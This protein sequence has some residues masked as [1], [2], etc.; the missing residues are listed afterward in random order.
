VIGIFDS[1]LGGLTVLRRVRAEL[2][3][4]PL[5]YFADQAHVPYG[6]RSEADL[7]GLLRRN[8][9][10]LEAQGADFIVMGCNTSCA[11]GRRYGW[12]P[13]G[14]PILDLIDAAA[15]AV[16][17]AG[18]RRVGVIATSATANSGEYGAA[19]R[20]RVPGAEV[21]E[22]GAPELVPLVEAGK[23]TGPAA[24]DAVHR[25]CAP[26]A[27]PLDM[28]VLA[29]THF[30]LLDEHFESAFGPGLPRLDPAVAQAARAIAFARGRAPRL[31]L[32]PLPP[33]RTRFVTNGALPAFAAAVRRIVGPLQETEQTEKQD[34]GDEAEGRSGYDLHQRVR[35]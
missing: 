27:R 20:A 13:A 3:A 16:A 32:S 2:P 28:L 30:P 1:G 7:Q 5:L 12:P 33:A 23:V 4:E 18:A 35:A 6:D 25:A 26:F 9:A 22:V 17:A 24:R 29:C 11:V 19:I 34:D 14:V 21:Q 31:E 15:E 8:V 10:Y